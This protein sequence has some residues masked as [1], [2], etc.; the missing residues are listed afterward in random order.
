MAPHQAPSQSVYHQVVA[1][2]NSS[3]MSRLSLVEEATVAY[4]LLTLI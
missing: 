3:I 4:L 2:G 1:G